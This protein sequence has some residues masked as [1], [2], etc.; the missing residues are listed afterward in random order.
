M[1]MNLILAAAVASIVASGAVAQTSAFDNQGAAADALDDLEEDISDAADRDIGAFGT[2]GREVG[3]YGSIALNATATS[4]ET[5]VGAGLRWGTFD[6]VNGFDMSFSYAY[7]ADENGDATENQLLAGLD[8]RR[9]FG[10]SFFGYAQTDIAIDRLTTT[11]GDYKQDYFVGAGV[12]YRIYNTPD[13][14]WSVQAGPGYRYAE[15]VGGDDV[16]EVAGSLSNN[17]YYSLSDTIYATND[18]DVIYSE[19]ATTVAND[20]AINVAMSDTLTLRTSYATQFNDATD[21]SFSDA[22]NTFGL[23]VV[24]NFN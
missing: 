7:S 10:S 6:G 2:E 8:Y 18:T 11:A 1:Q 3:T 13:F 23:S 22:A 19:S 24:Y 14:Q 4:D 15:V 21:D 20:F 5:N 16:N 9:N 12:G 17:M